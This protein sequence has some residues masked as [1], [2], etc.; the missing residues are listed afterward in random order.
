MRV[1]ENQCVD[2]VNV[3]GHI[4]TESKVERKNE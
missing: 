4:K 1:I 2:T 3:S